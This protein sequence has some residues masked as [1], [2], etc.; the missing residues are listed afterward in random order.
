[1]A[2]ISKSGSGP[3]AASPL[4][5]R[6]EGRI[7]LRYFKDVLAIELAAV[8]RR[9]EAQGR[10]PVRPLAPAPD[11]P[12]PHRHAAGENTTTRAP[13]P[14]HGP[15]EAPPFAPG[16][17]GRGHAAPPPPA[18]PDHPEPSLMRPQPLPADLTGLALSGGGIR[19]AAVALGALQALHNNGRI[20]AIDYLSTVSGGGYMGACLSAA[21]AASGRFPFGDDIADSVAVAHLRNFSNYLM[22]RGRSRIRNLAEAA[23]V[24]LRGLLANAVIV[25]AALLGCA[26]VTL[27]AFPSR[28]ALT[29]GSFVPR[30]IDNIVAPHRGHPVSRAVGSFPFSLTLWLLGVLALALV[31]WALL[32]SIP[33]TRAFASDAGSPVLAAASALIV[34]TAA[35]AFLDL[36]PLAIE[37]VI[38]LHDNI[39]TLAQESV[40]W[41]QRLIPALAAFSGA[42]SILSG[43]LGRFLKTSQ[44]ATDRKTLLLRAATH[45]AV[46]VAAMVLPLLLWLAYLYLAAWCIND[47][48][49]PDALG[50]EPPWRIFLTAFVPLALITLGLRAN[51]YSLNRFYRD[52]LAQAF[53]FDPAR[54]KGDEP[55]PLDRLRL[56]QLSDRAPYHLLN[57][58]LNV[59]GSAEANRRG[60]NADFFLLSRHFVGS[61]LTLYAPTCETSAPAKGRRAEGMEA[62]DPQL[63]L[64]TA[65]AISGAAVSANMGT[66]TVRLLSPTLALLNIRLGY[67][68]R[69]P[70]DLARPRGL[71][72]RTLAAV[73]SVVTDKLYLLAEMLNLLDET[74]RNLFLTDGGHIENLGLYELLKRGCALVVVIDAEAD[75][76]LS[77]PSLIRLERYARIDLGVRIALPWEAIARTSETVSKSLEKGRAPA[78]ARGPHCAVGRIFYESGAEGVLV[79]VKSS[80]TGDEKDYILDY[81]TRYPAFPHE[82]TSDQF[83]SEEQFEAYRALGF[84]MVDG[85]FAGNDDFAWLASGPGAFKDRAA[86]FAAVTAALP[87][88]A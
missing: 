70:R 69:N 71:L 12:V 25:A 38:R 47:W 39:S 77:F 31:V 17:S 24:I 27:L 46:F 61:D 13:A 42:V 29:D 9:R 8:N 4:Q 53:L 80:L 57:A 48:P 88:T 68:L 79:Y 10:K 85:F 74:R 76:S 37:L 75:P 6:R 11:A 52:R 15:G 40:A 59:Q 82:T 28:G 84:H 30:L 44:H 50:G 56:S 20:G 87:A 19:S 23:A 45:A 14:P 60:R 58:A 41:L 51:A 49:M 26:L 66:D 1:M 43:W 5:H 83:F 18:D 86:A 62:V 63:D 55:A 64:A 2:D 65:M 67:W 3:R 32:R 35:C 34:A 22:P 54:L 73:T 7:R 36:Q 21:M 81:K 78:P 33:R 16:D 72:A